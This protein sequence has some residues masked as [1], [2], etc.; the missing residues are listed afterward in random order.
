MKIIFILMMALCFMSVE[1]LFA[2]TSEPL[3]PRATAHQYT[4]QVNPNVK[5]VN[6]RTGIRVLEFTPASDPKKFCII[7]W[8]GSSN[9]Q[10]ECYN[11]NGK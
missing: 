4:L 8:V 6:N 9:R 5:R 11:K 1:T 2:A 3:R 10:F 7:L